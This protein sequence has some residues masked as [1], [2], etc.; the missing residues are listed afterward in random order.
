MLCMRCGLRQ[1]CRVCL[2]DSCCQRSRADRWAAGLV[3]GVIS[4]G[5]AVGA[6]T[7][8]QQLVHTH[9]CLHA[10]QLTCR[11]N[12][13]VRHQVAGVQH[14]HG[15]RLECGTLGWAVLDKGL[16]EAASAPHSGVAKKRSCRLPYTP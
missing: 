9:I 11:H 2:Q 7:T 12:S 6:C 4:R 16:A 3:A 13:S 10:C 8:T 15:W 1:Q 14:Q 5:E